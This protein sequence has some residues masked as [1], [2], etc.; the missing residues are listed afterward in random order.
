[1]IRLCSVS[2]EKYI[3][4]L[5]FLAKSH[6]DIFFQRARG[7]KTDDFFLC[8]STDLF[9]YPQR[10]QGTPTAKDVFRAP[11]KMGK[12]RTFGT[13]AARR[14]FSAARAARAPPE[15]ASAQGVAK[16]GPS[17]PPSSSS[18]S[19]KPLPGVFFFFPPASSRSVQFPARASRVRVVSFPAQICVGNLRPCVLSSCGVFLFAGGD[20]EKFGSRVSVEEG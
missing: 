6:F 11:E 3:F 2:R 12:E 14:F 19:R 17:A 7:K 20:E 8:Q 15:C 16:G 4:I 1:M 13:F 18:P 10:A 9:F 5:L